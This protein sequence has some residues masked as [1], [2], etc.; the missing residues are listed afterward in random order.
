MSLT[1]A[2]CAEDVVLVA[3]CLTVAVC[4]EDVVLVAACLSLLLFVLKMLS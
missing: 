4:V 1:V 3:A 2:V